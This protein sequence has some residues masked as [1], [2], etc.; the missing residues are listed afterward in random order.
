MGRLQ[1]SSCKVLVKESSLPSVWHTNYF[2]LEFLELNDR[3]LKLGDFK[4]N[5]NVPSLKDLAMLP[6]KSSV[7]DGAE[8]NCLT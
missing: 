7:I 4:N 8:D 6:I 5:P 3:V 2:N 1:D